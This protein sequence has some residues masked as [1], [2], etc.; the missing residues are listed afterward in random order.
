MPEPGG[1]AAAAGRGRRAIIAGSGFAALGDEAPRL[2][3]STR[4][5][6]PSSAI[7]RR[8]FGAEDVYVLLRHGEAHDIAPHAINY[9]ANLKALSLIGVT[10]VIAINTVGSIARGVRPGQ[11]A[12]PSQLIDYSWGR[13]HSIY[14]EPCA[15]LDHVDFTRPVAEGLRQQLLRAARQVGAHCH[16]GG[17][18][19]VTQGPRL[20]T[21]AEVD[22]YERDGV[23]YLGMT[24]M[25]EA[26]IARE[27]GLDYAMLS[28][29]VN[30]A[31]GRGARAIHEDIEVSTASARRAALAVLDSFF[32]GGEAGNGR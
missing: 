30:V 1:R 22:R 20:E 18:Y 19:G 16:D 14:D 21:A 32:G 3:V 24:G 29:V 10:T 17:V 8:R 25:P 9:R 15:N 5:G 27:L 6:R 12:V 4:Y 11:L 13:V 26:G 7:R 2:T 28:L 31:A 23:D